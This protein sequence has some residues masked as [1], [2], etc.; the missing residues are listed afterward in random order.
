MRPLKFTLALLFALAGL[1]AESENIPVADT[2][3]PQEYHE[4]YPFS[5]ADVGEVFRVAP[6][7]S[8]ATSSGL[9]AWNAEA[10]VWEQRGASPKPVLD[11][12]LDAKSNVAFLAGLDGLHTLEN[13]AV[14][15]EK[16][17]IAVAG[18]VGKKGTPHYLVCAGA[19]YAWDASIKSYKVL[20]E[21]LPR[22]IRDAAEDPKDKSL[23]IATGMG[24]CHVTYKSATQYQKLGDILSSDVRAVAFDARG[25]LWA[26]CFGGIAVFENGKMTETFTPANGLPMLDATALAR[27]DNGDMWV[28]MA[29]GAARFDGKKWSARFSRRWLVDD[30]VIDLAFNDG[31]L[32]V[33]TPK[34]VSAIK[35][36]ECTLE[37]KAEYFHDVAMQRHYREPGFVEKCILPTPGDTSKWEP[38]DDDNDGEYTSEFL[39]M[40]SYRYAATKDKEA[41]KRAQSAFAALKF[42]QTVT[43][44]DGFYARTVVPPD[45]THPNDPNVEYTE[46]EIALLSVQD[47]RFKPV[48]VRWHLSADGKW[49]WKGD[50]S[51]DEMCGH[52][53]AYHM[54]HDLACDESEKIEVAGHAA[55]IMDYLIAGGYNFID[56]DGTHTRWGVWSPDML[57]NDPEWAAE[58]GINSAE[59]LSYLLATWHMTGNDKYRNEYKRLL[60]EEHFLDNVK[61]AKTFA[62]AWET[63]IDDTLLIKVFPALLLYETEPELL[64][65][66]RQALEDWY[67]GIRH[68]FNPFF[69]FTYNWLGK[70]T[71][72]ME[73]SIFFFRDCPKDLVYWYMDQ[74]WRE[75]LRIVR[76]P[77]WEERSMSRLVPPSERATIRW[78]KNPWMI[79]GGDGGQTEWAPTFWLL[80][81]WMGRHLGYI[82]AP[83]IGIDAT[84]YCPI[85]R[86]TFP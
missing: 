83:Q 52:F 79:A 19:A 67:A 32:W 20:A 57:N 66:Y 43:G 53:W 37:E 13:S 35:T 27:G 48:E 50:T 74:S 12:S 58:R 6:G 60:Y 16:T 68:E 62:P 22:S 69:N 59:L 30:Q 51:S 42:L 47:P 2:P 10:N 77:I 5:D 46:E 8:V 14:I 63:H 26:A 9:W 7:P 82:A 86:K 11:F 44:T 31:A 56:V 39:V 18:S 70:N 41:K 33:A 76:E 38:E 75:D 3:F 28:G 34:G 64:A 80:P 17:V 4:A 54:Y 24:L 65:V 21:N 29:R 40:E 25:R 55:K 49:L 1:Y 78:D 61:N 84:V 45:W 81:Y 23:W 85:F 72:Q 36:R 71:A 73:D 15:F